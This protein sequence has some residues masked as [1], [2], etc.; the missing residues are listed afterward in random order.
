VRSGCC[1]LERTHSD[2][3]VINRTAVFIFSFVRECEV[4]LYA[5]Q[6]NKYG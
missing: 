1:N 2:I 4:H 6:R 3:T 5:P